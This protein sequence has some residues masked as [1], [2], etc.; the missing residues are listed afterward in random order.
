MFGTIARKKRTLEHLMDTILKVCKK[1]I[2]PKPKKIIY[3][4][5]IEDSIQSLENKLKEYPI[6]PRHLLR[7]VSLKIIDG[8]EKI[9]K[10]IE[11]NFSISLLDNI[12]IELI[13]V[14]ILNQLKE[15]NLV[16]EN[17]KDMIVSSIM[18]Q[19]E[20]ICKIVCTFGNKNYSRQRPKD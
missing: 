11:E 18:K 16:N 17:F 4:S 7:W 8:E 14:K 20:I 1:E 2:I 6:L 3:P 13:R 10:S 12:G 15:H 19:A 9:L 5:V